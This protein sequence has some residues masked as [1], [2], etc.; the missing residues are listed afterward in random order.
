MGKSLGWMR[1]STPSRERQLPH[2]LEPKGEP[3]RLYTQ[4]WKAFSNT[5]VQGAGVRWLTQREG[6]VMCE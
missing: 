3:C 5:R 2:Y 6:G 4:T 1:I